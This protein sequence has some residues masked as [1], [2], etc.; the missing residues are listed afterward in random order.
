M[1]FF[2]FTPV[3]AVV[4]GEATG[5]WM[6]DALARQHTRKHKGHL[7]PEVRLRAVLFSMPFVIAGLVLIGQ[8]LENGWHYMATS[9]CW[10]MYVFA[11]MI[12]TA[13]LSS[14]CLDSCPEASGEVSAWLNMARTLGGFIISY[15]QVRWTTAQGTTL[16]FGIQGA[17]CA[18]AFLPVIVLLRCGKAMQVWAGPLNFATT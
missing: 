5:H 6:H 3:V 8:C 17:V 7:E 4:L 2:Y 14:Y 13:A 1:G 12:T 9:V 10:D 11:M 15:F 18:D 16:S